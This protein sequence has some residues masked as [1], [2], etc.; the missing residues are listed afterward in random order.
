MGIED[1]LF[2]IAM[3]KKG[4]ETRIIEESNVLLLK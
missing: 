2:Q 3:M 4:I 1:L